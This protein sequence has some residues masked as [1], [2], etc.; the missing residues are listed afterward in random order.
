MFL[1]KLEDEELKR[2]KKSKDA[3]NKVIKEQR[4]QLMVAIKLNQRSARALIVNRLIK[5]FDEL[6]A[7]SGHPV[8]IKVDDLSMCIDRDILTKFSVS[9]YKGNFWTNDLKIVDKSLVIGYQ[10]FPNKGVVE[11]FEL[12]AYQVELLDGLPTIDL[13]E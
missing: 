12:P 13:K 9:F 4:K 6:R 7:I 11:L 2:I 10:K 1:R 8:I 5:Q 3:A